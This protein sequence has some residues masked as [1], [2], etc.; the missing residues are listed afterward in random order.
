MARFSLTDTLICGCEGLYTCQLHLWVL[1]VFV[2]LFVLGC[3]FAPYRGPCRQHVAA[4]NRACSCKQHPVSSPSLGWWCHSSAP[5]LESLD[6]FHCLGSHSLGSANKGKEKSGWGDEI[7][8]KRKTWEQSK[9]LEVSCYWLDFGPAW[10]FALIRVSSEHGRSFEKPFP[11]LLASKNL[12][13][14]LRR[15]TNFQ[16]CRGVSM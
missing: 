11:L 12:I 7:S 5:L 15:D 13:S 3:V 10:S 14:H 4:E 16:L 1:C 9:K 2:Y 8:K 6:C